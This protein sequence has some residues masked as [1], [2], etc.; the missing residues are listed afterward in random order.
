[1]ARG[2]F[3]KAQVDEIAQHVDAHAMTLV[4]LKSEKAPR[5][6]VQ[7][8]ESL[9]KRLE[10]SIRRTYSSPASDFGFAEFDSKGRILIILWVGDS[11]TELVSVSETD[12]AH[13]QEIEESIHS[14]N[15]YSDLVRHGT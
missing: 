1:M 10:F 3:T 9:A 6:L 5:E 12:E 4:I 15:F 8:L 7:R 11:R 14:S 2:I 13:I